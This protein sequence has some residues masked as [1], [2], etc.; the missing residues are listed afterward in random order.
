MDEKEKIIEIYAESIRHN[1][2]INK[3]LVTAVVILGI[4]FCAAITIICSVVPYI[5][6]T[7]DYYYPTVETTD[8]DNAT[9]TIGG[10]K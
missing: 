2:E 5:Y 9:T 6:F 8:S 10:E 3:R 1:D 4:S 7:T